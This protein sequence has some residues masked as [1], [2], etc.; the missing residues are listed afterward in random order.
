MVSR[1]RT[2]TGIEDNP[3]IDALSRFGAFING[4]WIDE[5]LQLCTVEKGKH[6]IPPSAICLISRYDEPEPADQ[7]T[8][9]EMGNFK[10]TGV[11]PIRFNKI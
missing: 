10:R 6:W 8:E 2:M 7:W 11:K 4:F 9:E 1:E 3:E 5:N